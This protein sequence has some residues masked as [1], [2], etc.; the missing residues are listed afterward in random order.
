MKKEASNPNQWSVEPL[1]GVWC[2]VRVQKG[3]GKL[4]S[5][6]PFSSVLQLYFG[7]SCLY[8]LKTNFQNFFLK[9]SEVNHVLTYKKAKCKRIYLK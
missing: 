7:S 5:K 9:R 4:C 2:A 1:F 8:E 6:P 3:R